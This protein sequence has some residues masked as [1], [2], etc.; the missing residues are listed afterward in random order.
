M[1][2]TEFGEAQDFADFVIASVM[3]GATAKVAAESAVSAFFRQGKW[4]PR[5]TPNGRRLSLAAWRPLRE[6]ILGR[7]NYICVYCGEGADCVDHIIPLVKGG[8]NAEDNLAAACSHCNCSK[9]GKLISE[10]R[11][12]S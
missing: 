11:R 4:V 9:G 5:P 2:D 1:T 6:F 3:N 10:W 8:T 7:D 12:L